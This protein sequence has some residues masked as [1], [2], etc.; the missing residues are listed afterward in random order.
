M[1]K[2]YICEN[3]KLFL[4]GGDKKLKI[5]FQSILAYIS[6]A[7]NRLCEPYIRHISHI[8]FKELYEIRLKASGVMAR[9][10]FSR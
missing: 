4:K 6:N 5:K 1:R 10:T 8:K 7:K 3:V 9:V 2:I